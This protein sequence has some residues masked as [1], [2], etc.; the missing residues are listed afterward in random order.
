[1]CNA[2]IP[3]LSSIFT[4]LQFASAWTVSKL[5][6]IISLDSKYHQYAAIFSCLTGSNSCKKLL[7]RPENDFNDVRPIIK[8]PKTLRLDP[9]FQYVI[10]KAISKYSLHNARVILSV[11][12]KFI[13]EYLETAYYEQF[14]SF[15]KL[16]DMYTLL[17]LSVRIEKAFRYART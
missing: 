8:Q 14:L 15:Y 12:S 13:F 6:K 1:M 10:W 5:P 9:H 3:L 16:H 11:S 2:V 4:F 17:L 7:H